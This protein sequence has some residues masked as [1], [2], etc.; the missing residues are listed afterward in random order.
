MTVYDII[1]YS[2]YPNHAFAISFVYL[3]YLISLNLKEEG[4]LLV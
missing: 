4:W 1:H 2:F 3:Q